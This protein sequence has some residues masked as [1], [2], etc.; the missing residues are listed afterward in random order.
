MC[1]HYIIE[2]VKP[3]Q[4]VNVFRIVDFYAHF[5]CM[6][7]TWCIFMF[8]IIMLSMKFIFIAISL[9][10]FSSSSLNQTCFKKVVFYSFQIGVPCNWY[11]HKGTLFNSIQ[12]NSS[13]FAIKV[14]RFKVLYYEIY[15]LLL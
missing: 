15:L 5:F 8:F 6:L 13:L 4:K 3:I 11:R 9:I 7:L 1:T 14:L 2:K 12:F 10:F